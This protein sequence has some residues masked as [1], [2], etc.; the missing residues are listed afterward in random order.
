VGLIRGSVSADFGSFVL[1]SISLS[2][3]SIEIK[4]MR[5]RGVLKLKSHTSLLSDKS[6]SDTFLG[7]FETH[8]TEVV[9]FFLPIT[10]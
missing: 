4:E 9:F 7:A 6:M 2:H 3:K 5:K 1:Q 8:A 10:T